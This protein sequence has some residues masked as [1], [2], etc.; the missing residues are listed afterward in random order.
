[1]ASYWRSSVVATGI[2][3]QNQLIQ[4]LFMINNTNTLFNHHPETLVNPNPDIMESIPAFTRVSVRPNPFSNTLTLEIASVL[5]LQVV[6][7]LT[8]ST[9]TIVKLFGWYLLKGT[10]VTTLRDMNKLAAGSYT[11][12]VMN[13]EGEVIHDAMVNK[14]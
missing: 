7:K 14:S 1:M 2:S 13:N 4:T 10:N 6:V 9:G 3:R 5:N 11:L 8:N 12:T